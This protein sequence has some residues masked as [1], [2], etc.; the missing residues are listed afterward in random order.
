MIFNQGLRQQQQNNRKQFIK[1]HLP[2]PI[3]AVILYQF[4]PCVFGPN[5]QLQISDKAKRTIRNDTLNLSQPKLTTLTN[6]SVE[7]K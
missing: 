4:P 6:A 1:T 3:T 2:H 5:C 7:S